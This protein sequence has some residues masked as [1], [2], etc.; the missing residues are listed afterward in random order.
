LRQRA[1]WRKNVRGGA[2]FIEFRHTAQGWNPH[3]H[4]IVES[5]FLP[6]GT[7]RRHWESVSPGKIV[8]IRRIPLGSAVRYVTKYCTKLDLPEVLQQQASDALKSKRL[9]TLFGRWALV[10]KSGYV[11]GVRC[12][13]CG[14]A[15][16]FFNPFGTID[17]WVSRKLSPY[18]DLPPREPPKKP[19]P[20]EV[21]VQSQVS[22]SY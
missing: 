8:D 3:L 4:V 5:A 9:F 2:Y 1:W 20:G 7:I 11:E 6:V 18:I 15:A 10:P 22:F 21:E 12:T 17:E 16:W 13:E 14:V 19:S